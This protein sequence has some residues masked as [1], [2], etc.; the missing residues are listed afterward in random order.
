MRVRVCTCVYVCV[1]VCVRIRVCVSVRS[2]LYLFQVS[3]LGEGLAVHSQ[4]APADVRP[5]HDKMEQ[6]YLD[7]QQKFYP[8]SIPARPRAATV[9][10]C[11]I[12]RLQ[13]CK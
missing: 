3:V 9:S 6:G 10:R 5:L 11:S 2:T 8:E 1:Y 4:I 13:D 7:M 12:W